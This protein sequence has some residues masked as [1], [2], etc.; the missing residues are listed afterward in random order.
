MTSI[1]ASYTLGRATRGVVGTGSDGV[2][3]VGVEA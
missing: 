3:D 1:I 2:V